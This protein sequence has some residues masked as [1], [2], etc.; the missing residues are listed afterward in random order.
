M[1]KF[2]VKILLL[3]AEV[4]MDGVGCFAA[5]SHGE[6][7]GSGS[8]DGVASREDPFAARAALFAGPYAAAP[9]FVVSVGGRLVVCGS[10]V[11][12]RRPLC[13]RAYLCRVRRWST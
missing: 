4:F 6:D 2:E 10:C 13:S 12:L 5:G 8:C 3:A 9:I 7:Y 11:P 1:R